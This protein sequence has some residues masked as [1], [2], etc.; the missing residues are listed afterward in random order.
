LTLQEV[1]TVVSILG[2]AA[3][4][5][6]VVLNEVRNYIRNA[7]ENWAKLELMDERLKRIEQSVVTL[8]HNSEKIV[9]VLLSKGVIKPEE[10]DD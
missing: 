4:V 10:L 8:N 2:G 6:A 7:A 3:T 5:V 9:R 1:V